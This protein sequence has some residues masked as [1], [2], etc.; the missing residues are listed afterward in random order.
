M[1]KNKLLKIEQELVEHYPVSNNAIGKIRPGW[2][3]GDICMFIGQAPGALDIE[4][5][6]VNEIIDEKEYYSHF[7]NDKYEMTKFLREIYPEKHWDDISW[8]NVYKTGFKAHEVDVTENQK[9]DFYLILGE[10]IDAVKPKVIVAVGDVAKKAIERVRL[11]LEER[12][13]DNCIFVPHWSY[14]RRIGKYDE[15]VKQLRDK[16]EEAV[17]NYYVVHCTNLSKKTHVKTDFWSRRVSGFEFTPYFYV[18][19]DKLTV[20]QFVSWEGKKLRKIVDE[21][22][23]NYGK[24]YEADVYP[25]IRFLIDNKC[26]FIRKQKIAF[27]DIETN[28]SLDIF[29]SPEPVIS[30][31]LVSG[32]HKHC[33]TW[34]ADLR[35]DVQQKDEMTLFS[36]DDERKMLQGF[37]DF[38]RG[39][40]FDV[41]TGWN[42]DRFDFPYLFN[43]IKNLGLD[44]SDLSPMG[45]V[46]FKM[47]IT[48]DDFRA[49]VYGVDLID[50]MKVFKKITYEKRPSSYSLK[51]IA[52]IVLDDEKLDMGMRVG[53]AWKTNIE[54]LVEYNL[55]DS[56]LIQ[57]IN[58]K[59]H[60]LDYM[61]TL[62]E[63]SSCPLDLCIFNKNV[64]DCYLLKRYHDEIVFPT[65][66]DNVKEDIEGAVTGKL[67]FDEKGDFDSVAPDAGLFKNVAVLDFSCLVAG[68]KILMSNFVE[69]N[70]EELKIGDRVR[71]L[72]EDAKIYAITH[73]Q[74]KRV[75]KIKLK[76]GQEIIATENHRFFRKD[77]SI[78]PLLSSVISLKIG[79]FLYRRVGRCN[80][81]IIGMSELTKSDI[82]A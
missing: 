35:Q 10:Q 66:V 50:L 8:T 18:E 27:F 45:Y 70:I 17:L 13:L 54:R 32:E 52:K 51:N 2:F 73:Y 24:T 53:E 38:F 47:G 80:K 82:D 4:D 6:F 81:N 40:N 3:K 14:L 67:V 74:A 39:E 65:I 37:M 43:R 68:T 69:K 11:G 23:R 58:E 77:D 55:K 60:L 46:S 19:D 63:I 72:N 62:Q 22:A 59:A 26:R 25:N 36:F 28:E 1:D 29:T 42:A 44:I 33:W 16:I 41:L 71:G 49:R 9:E 64:V 78:K 61:M 21:D 57:R 48:K 7:K 75:F 12:G 34:R 76:S 56:T 5:H 79:D 31:S 20:G 15:E 30:I